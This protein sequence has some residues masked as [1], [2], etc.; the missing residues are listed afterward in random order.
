M[1]SAI[2]TSAD[3]VQDCILVYSMVGAAIGILIPKLRL[4]IKS[5]L[6]NW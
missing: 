6:W 1:N 3:F 5:F 4:R 2:R